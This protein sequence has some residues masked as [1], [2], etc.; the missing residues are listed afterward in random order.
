[1]KEGRMP[2]FDVVTGVLFTACLPGVL[3]EVNLS[4]VESGRQGPF[5]YSQVKLRIRAP[6]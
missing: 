1:M 5:V 4:K 2:S 3:A 6:A